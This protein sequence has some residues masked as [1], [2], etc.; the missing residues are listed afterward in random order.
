MTVDLRSVVGRTIVR[1][2]ADDGP[3]APRRP[4]RR[5]PRLVGELAV[6]LVLLVVYDHLR[7]RAA[8][9]TSIALSHGRAVL[10]AERALHLDIEH[11]VNGWLSSHDPVRLLA[12]GYYQYLH[13]GI[14]LTVL[15]GCYIWRPAGYRRARNAL[16]LTNVVGLAVFALY[17]TAPPRLLPG[18]GFVDSV[19][20]TG[21][22]SHGPVAAD[23]YG[24]LPSLH[25]AWA[26]WA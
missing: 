24:A 1:Q 12:V 11:A 6:V 8:V 16:V 9:R 15:A 4:V 19:A 5:R 14:A 7:A 2:D 13:I 3:G 26:T 20:Q 21:F 22:A 10:D 17:P 18:A 23:Q 25:L